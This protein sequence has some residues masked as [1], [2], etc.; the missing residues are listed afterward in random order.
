VTALDGFNNTATG[1]RGTVHFTTTDSGSGASVPADYTFVAGDNG[2]H[3]FPGGVTFVTAGNQTLTATD[4]VTSSITGTSAAVAVN[5]AAATHFSVSAPS[6]ATAGHAFNI[7]VTAL[8]AFNNTATG[9]R[10]TVHFTTTDKGISAS[11]PADYTFVSGDNGVHTFP[12]G[13]TLVT[14]GNQTVTATDTVTTT[15]TGTSAAVAVSAAAAS[16]FSVSGPGSTTAGN[17]F[18]VTVTALDAY[19]NTATSYRGTVH[20]TTTDGGASVPADYTFV[21]GDNGVHTFTDGVTLVSAGSQTVTVTDTV[22]STITGTSNPIAVAAAAATHL[23]VSAPASATAGTAFNF[24]VTALDRFNNTATG[25]TGTVHFSSSDTAGTL[26]ADG[27]LTNGV[28]TFSATLR[29]AGNQ[30]LTATDTVTSTITGTSKAIAVGAAAATHFSLS[31]PATATAGSA[32]SVTVTAL[33]AYGNTAT[34]YGGTVHLTT[35]D[36]GSGVAVPADYTFVSGDNGTHTFPNG[37]TLVTAGNQ[38]VTVTDTATSITGTSAAIEV[39]ASAATHFAVSGPSTV[40]AGTAFTLTVRAL[41]V[42]NNTAT[43]YSGTV[44]FTSSDSAAAL[45]ADSTLTSGSGTF[46]A[47]LKT[48]ANQTISATDTAVSSITG[49]SNPIGVSAAAA[50]HF[51]VTAPSTATAGTA[52]SV[53]VTAQD[54][55]NNTASS[56]LGTIHFTKTD[57]GSG[58]AVPADYTFVAGDNGV[59]TFTGGVTLVTAGNQTLTATDTLTSGVT[60]TSNAIAVSAIAATHF[61]VSAPSSATAGS[62]FSVTVTAL[63]AFNNTATSYRG[64]VHF[65]SSDSGPGSAVP[66]DYTF[67]SGDNGV[68]TFTDGGTSVTAGNQ[69]LTAIDTVVSS[70]TGASSAIAVVAAAATR[71]SV[72]VPGTATAGS[73]FSMIVTALD[74]FGNTATGY[75]GTVHFT[76]SDSQAAL[77]VNST[78]TNGTGTF[79]LTLKTAGNQTVTATDTTTS[80]INGTSSPVSVSATIVDHFLVSAPATAVTGNAFS[81]T[82]TAVDAS[83]NLVPTYSGTVHFTSSDGTANLPADSTITGGTGS[84]SATLNK[85]GS[86]TITATDTVTSSITGTSAPIVVRGLTVTSFTPTATGFS[87]TFSKPFVNTSSNPIPLYDAASA[88][89]GP[90]DV[91]LVGSGGIGTVR[92]SLIIDPSNTSFTFVKTD[93]TVGGGTSGLLAPGTYTVTFLSGPT[94][95]KDSSGVALDGNGDGTSHNYVTTFTVAAPTGVVV[96]I[97]D[98]ARGP[99][100]NDVINLPNNSTNGIPIALSNG[101]GVTDATFVLQYN[102]NLLTITGGT[103]NSALTGATFTVTTSGSGSSAQATIVFHSPTPLA[104]GAVRLGGLTATVPSNAPYKAKALL[105]FSSLSLNGGAIAAVADDGLQAVTFLGDTSGDG[106]YTGADSVLIARVASQADSG[107]AAFPV[108]DPAIVGDLNGD[109]RLTAADGGLFNNYLAGNAVVQV[110]P[111][112]GVPSNNPS[113]PDPTLSLTSDLS[114]GP[115][116][117]VQIA[118]N[119]DDPYPVGSSGLTQAQLALSYDPAML[120]VSAADIHLG[121]VP[122]SGTGWT[123]QAVVNQATGQIGVSLFSVTPIRTSVGGSLVTIDLHVQPGVSGGAP[124]LN[125]VAAVNPTGRSVIQTALDDNQGPLTLHAAPPN[126]TVEPGENGR[127]GSTTANASALATSNSAAPA[128]LLVSV[129]DPVGAST[130]AEATVVVLTPRVSAAPATVANLLLGIMEGEQIEPPSFSAPLVWGSS[131]ARLA[132]ELVFQDLAQGANAPLPQLLVDSGRQDLDDLFSNLPQVTRTVPDELMA[133]L[134]ESRDAAL[135][136]L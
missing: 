84:F 13:V 103:V 46:A 113:G 9:Y 19:G 86:Q 58:S 38:T 128:D 14:A 18:S 101:A 119:I 7:T 49:T 39:G 96:S 53:T 6:S 67:V 85:S 112:P 80:S 8:D 69:T 2:V 83:N 111:Y 97:P 125:L 91:T 77:P 100:G 35:T 24:T 63:D 106:T 21:S 57:T 29:T 55:F 90:P 52:F 61:S 123:L 41:D 60:G 27:T 98:F 134:W 28:S 110:P 87:A 54:A 121:S 127:V 44:Y 73:A 117:T 78:L 114:A 75:S 25:Y 15:L 108:L 59:H 124:L 17:A 135:D 37:V 76:S 1:Y 10:G 51:A 107:L 129:E 36:S 102:A 32:F 3:T 136:S 92:G 122:A 82:V 20:F 33:D 4:T 45:P 72:S 30:T 95:F 26:P 68:H 109:G 89:Y 74:P 133:M 62:A 105:H 66:A 23:A 130:T 94:G 99:D 81:F 79:S 132:Q 104:S 11:A 34:G 71:F 50:T 64:T 131:V 93:L 48:A 47:I 40:T 22:T 43:G 42:F 115:D 118:V 12:D 116:G 31:T 126:V 5:P 70:I 88:S 65:T 16:H 120:S 56:Y